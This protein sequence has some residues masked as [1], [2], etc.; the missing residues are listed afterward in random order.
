MSDVVVRG[1][2]PDEIRKNLELW[3]GC[4]AGALRDDEY[5][6]KLAKAGFEGI[7]IESTR[8]YSIEDARTSLCGQGVDVDAMAPAVDGKVH[9]RVYPGEQAR[10]L[11]VL[12]P[13]LLLLDGFL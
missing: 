11:I 2:V 12:R 4:I 13:R 10:Y 5:V 6:A 8:I 9:A 3:V 7:E 1:K